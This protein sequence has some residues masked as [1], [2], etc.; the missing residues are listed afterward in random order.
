VAPLEQFLLRDSTLY[1]GIGKLFWQMFRRQFSL[2]AGRKMLCTIFRRSRAFIALP[3]MRRLPSQ[4]AKAD[5]VKQA[6]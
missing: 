6:L 5:A 4:Q 3:G 1:F 2:V